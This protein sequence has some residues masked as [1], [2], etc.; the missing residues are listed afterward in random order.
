MGGGTSN[1]KRSGVLLDIISMI[2]VP[3]HSLDD[4]TNFI[5]I[6]EE[7]LLGAPINSSRADYDGTNDVINT[8]C[9]EFLDG[10]N[11]YMVLGV[12]IKRVNT[13]KIKNGRSKGETMAFLTIADNSCAVDDVVC[14]SEEWRQYQN[15][16]QPE[17]TVII[18]GERDKKKG[19]LIIK[20]TMS[21]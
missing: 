16:L 19:S 7:K 1:T 18:N 3:P 8:N 10:K 9:K 4:T 6:Q 21:Y 20:K 14:F 2:E 12:E 13:Y 11:G 15:M 17:N 5:A